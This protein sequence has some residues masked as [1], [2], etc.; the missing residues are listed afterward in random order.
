[1]L[2]NFQFETFVDTHDYAFEEYLSSVIARLV[3]ENPKY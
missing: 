1:M 3:K 2:D